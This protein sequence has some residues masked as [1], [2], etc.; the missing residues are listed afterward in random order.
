MSFYAHVFFSSS[1]AQFLSYCITL[2]LSCAPTDT[3][4][5]HAVLSHERFP[6]FV[7]CMDWFRQTSSVYTHTPPSLSLSLCL[8]LNKCNY[9]T[10]LKWVSL[11]R[12]I[13]APPS[14]MYCRCVWFLLICSPLATYLHY[15][16]HHYIFFLSYS[17]RKR[18]FPF[19]CCGCISSCVCTPLCHVYP[20]I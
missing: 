10:Y 2:V 18:I 17:L 1:R 11:Q 13:V 19:W 9:K 4:H 5:A 6:P 20:C 14:H 7:D 12:L 16:W 15:S 3:G 8:R